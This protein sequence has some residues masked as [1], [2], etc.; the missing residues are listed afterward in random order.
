MVT[1]HEFGREELLKMLWEHPSLAQLEITRNCNQKCCFC[2][3]GCTNQCK[4]NNLSV[5]EW[6]RIIDKL[7]NLGIKNINFSGGEVFLFDDFEELLSYCRKLELK[8][9][10]NTN[11]TCDISSCILDI[12]K[13]IFSIHGTQE[14]HNKIVRND[15]SFECIMKNIRIANDNKVPVEINMTVVKS[16]FEQIFEVYNYLTE[17]V[18]FEQFS[19]TLAIQCLN[20]TD[21]PQQE[22]FSYSEDLFKKYFKVLDSI[23][24][25]RLDLKQ[26]LHSMYFN[27]KQIYENTTICDS[28]YCIGGKTKLV[29]D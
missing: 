26:G 22:S 23:P 8:T 28:P 6:K 29:I 4:Y 14:L 21:I 20:G 13:I 2:F 15:R 16:N 12:D 27:N 17:R 19:P 7:Y 9:V 1:L 11:G 24:K 5:E 10:V 25:N 3:Q 18:E